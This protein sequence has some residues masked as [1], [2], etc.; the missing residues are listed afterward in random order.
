MIPNTRNYRITEL[1]TRKLDVDDVPTARQSLAALLR[2]AGYEVESA[3]G[4]LSALRALEAHGA[5]LV[6]TDLYMPD[7]SGWDL[8]H[9]VRARGHVNSHGDPVCLGLYSALLSGFPREQLARHHVDFTIA[10]LTD[11]ESILDAVERALA[12]SD[13]G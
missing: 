1:Q 12:W 2:A 11:G 5:D 10:K 8:A 7:M 6:L 3:D 4:G 13:A 9:A